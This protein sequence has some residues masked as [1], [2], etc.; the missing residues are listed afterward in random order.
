MFPLTLPRPCLLKPLDPLSPSPADGGAHH[1]RRRAGQ[2]RARHHDPHALSGARHRSPPSDSSPG[3]GSARH[4]REGPGRPPSWRGGRRGPT[5]DAVQASVDEAGPKPWAGSTVRH[6]ERPATAA[7][8]RESSA[9]KPAACSTRRSQ[10]QPHRRFFNTLRA[11][12][13]HIAHERGLC[14]GRI[15]SLAAAVARPAARRLQRVEGGRRGARQHA[16]HGEL[17]STGRSG[18]RRLLRRVRPR[19]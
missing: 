4:R 2:S 3:R 16:P 7:A 13:P 8:A 12:G 17:Y 5:R 18:R 9:G 6:G 19:T 15:A 10:S 11:A 1:R 14:A